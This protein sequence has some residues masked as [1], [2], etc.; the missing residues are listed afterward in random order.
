MK[1]AFEYL[2]LILAIGVLGACSSQ[3]NQFDA[4]AQEAMASFMEKENQCFHM[5]RKER[6]T[7][8]FH[9]DLNKES[10][11]EIYYSE[12][13]FN[14]YVFVVRDKLYKDPDLTVL[15]ENTTREYLMENGDENLIFS[16]GEY[17]PSMVDKKNNFQLIYEAE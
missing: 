5:S 17:N 13:D 16:E 14:S 10:I 12:K 7:S 4:Q 11:K 6:D 15:E 3:K 2:L 1:K 8:S 9:E